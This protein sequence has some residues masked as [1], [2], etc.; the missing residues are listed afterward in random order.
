MTVREYM[1]KR[2]PTTYGKRVRVIDLR[3]GDGTRE[4]LMYA[5]RKVVRVSITTKILYI[6]VD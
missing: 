3:K 5:E 4:W 1:D 2:N 6:Y